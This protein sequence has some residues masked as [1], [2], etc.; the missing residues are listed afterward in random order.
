[1]RRWLALMVLALAASFWLCGTTPLRSAGHGDPAADRALDT[2]TTGQFDPSRPTATF[3]ADYAAVMGYLPQVTTGPHGTPIL[4]KVNGDCSSFTGNTKYDFSVVCKEHDL[5]YD[6]IRYAQ[7]VGRPLDP[8]ARQQADH[9]F[10]RDL[11]ARCDQLHV[12]GFDWG[13]CHTY[14]ESFVEAVRINS[15]RQGYHAPEQESPWRWTAM[16]LL[17][18]GFLCLPL[19]LQFL[20]DGGPGRPFAGEFLGGGVGTGQFSPERVTHSLHGMA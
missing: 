4:Y 15:W 5:S 12:T 1:M 8:T 9:M 6:L 18:G 3:P 19:T 11:H 2:V 10:G 17:F 7:R 20:R 16:L 13:M 14:A